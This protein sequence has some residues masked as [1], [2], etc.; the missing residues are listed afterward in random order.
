[1]Y[2]LNKRTAAFALILPFWFALPASAQTAT[3]PACPNVPITHSLTVG[4]RDRYTGGDVSRLQAFLGIT[5][6]GYFGS[7]T[8]GKVATW[9]A[10]NG[11][12][13]A[14]GYVGP[15]TRAAI[16]K[17]C[18]AQ[19]F[20]DIS[21]SGSPSTGTA[22]LQVA[23]SASGTGFG[24]GQYIIDYGDAAD[25]G[26]VTTTCATSNP[27][28]AAAAT[29]TCTLSASHT[30]QNA[31]AYT[32][33]LEPYVAC[34][35][36]TPRCLI[37]TQLLGSAT[38]TVGA[39]ASSSSLAIPGTITLHPSESAKDYGAYFTYTLT[40][41][42]VHLSASYAAQGLS[43]DFTWTESH[44]GTSGCS[45]A[46]DPG[47]QSFTLYLTNGSSTYTTSLGH[48]LTL[49]AVAANSA[50]VDISK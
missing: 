36:A 42:A 16:A 46:A 28:A 39:A 18:N 1:M 20:A 23:F 27:G 14:V 29:S 19:P 35:W 5:P 40:L 10:L 4:S 38:V 31:G 13:P 34:M 2:Y 8:R 25:S 43:A 33:S 49:T 21:F 6:T 26:P 30:Y 7:I 15:L 32:A 9:Q 48:V 45:G 17:R 41:D 12:T 11:I 50:T 3:T 47:P 22:P 44:C 24:A 37:P